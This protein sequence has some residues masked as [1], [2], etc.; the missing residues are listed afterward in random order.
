MR[1]ERD[2]MRGERDKMSGAYLAA[3]GVCS[4]VTAVA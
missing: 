1:G 2:K 4:L 3:V